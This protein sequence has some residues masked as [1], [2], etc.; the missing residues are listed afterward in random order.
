MIILAADHGGFELNQKIKQMF[1]EKGIDYADVGAHRFDALDNFPSYVA[2]GV[3]AVLDNRSVGI[4]ICGSGIGI[5]MAANRRRG[6]RA[7]LCHSVEY[8]KLAREHNNANVL[9]LGGRFLEFEE[10]EKIIDAFLNTEFLGGK[11]TAR[12]AML[13]RY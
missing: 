8:A 9:C 13:E 12:M 1:S 3:K 10:A 7:A 2:R 5:S 11:Y 6:I 4:F